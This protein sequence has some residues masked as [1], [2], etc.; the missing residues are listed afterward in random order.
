MLFETE[1]VSIYVGIHFVNSKKNDFNCRAS[2]ED[3]KHL[4]HR[5][6]KVS[7]TLLALILCYI[8]FVLP[9]VSCSFWLPKLRYDAD[10]ESVIHF[11]CFIVYWFEVNNDSGLF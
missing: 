5:D 11:I 8:A 9:I 1:F 7:W 10:V 2:E 4:E 6:W 3:R